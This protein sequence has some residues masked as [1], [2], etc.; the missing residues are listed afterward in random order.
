MKLVQ[1]GK[2]YVFF[3][4]GKLAA[5][6]P[7]SEQD[8]AAFIADCVSEVGALRGA[9]LVLVPLPPLGAGAGA[10]CRGVMGCA[11]APGCG[12]DV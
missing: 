7:I 9:A 4:D 8:L 1:E 11:G 10:V 12:L 2:P 6:K 5:C 3:G